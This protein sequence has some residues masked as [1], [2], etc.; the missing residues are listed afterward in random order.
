MYN[1]DKPV[2]SHQKGFNLSSGGGTGRASPGRRNR[3]HLPT[4]G[5]YVAESDLYTRGYRPIHGSSRFESG[6]VNSF[7]SG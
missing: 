4:I 3:T 6:Q 5:A 2:K 7:H 1:I